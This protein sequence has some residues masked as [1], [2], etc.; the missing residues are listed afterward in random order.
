MAVLLLAVGLS[1]D[2]FAV[3]VCKG[4]AMTRV[5][6]KH[7]LI[8]G[9]WFGAFQGLMPMAG[10]LLGSQFERYVSAFSPW[11]AFVLLALIGVNMLRE[12]VSDEEKP[13]TA[14]LRAQEM[15]LLAVATS[16]DALAVGVAYAM[17]PPAIVPGPEAAGVALACV[18]TAATTCVISMAG[19]RIGGAFGA[20]WKR[21]AG[22]AGG[23]IL[24]LIGVRILTR[25][26]GLF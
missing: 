21:R 23:V 1:M 19:V 14:T 7:M 15:L 13:E 3:A 18:L 26:L 12:A 17:V 8:V 4:L 11:V 22:I 20:R 5:S 2:A 25:R 24:I 16:I 6:P 10:Y 9:V